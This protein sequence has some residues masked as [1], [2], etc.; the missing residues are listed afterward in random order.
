MMRFLA[1]ILSLLILCSAT[2]S[3]PV[4]IE[5]IKASMQ[6]L[7]ES[8]EKAQET[9]SEIDAR[10]QIA[11]A[12]ETNAA[13]ALD[14]G[15]ADLSELSAQYKSLYDEAVEIVRQRGLINLYVQELTSAKELIVRT[16][17]IINPYSQ[18][19]CQQSEEISKER[20]ELKAGKIIDAIYKIEQEAARQAQKSPDLV[21]KA[22]K[23]YQKLIGLRDKMLAFANKLDALGEILDKLAAI[24]AEVKNNIEKAS[25]ELDKALPRAKYLELSADKNQKSIAEM[26]KQLD[27][28]SMTSTQTLQMRRQLD[29]LKDTLEKSVK[30]SQE[31]IDKLKQSLTSLDER[32]NRFELNLTQMNDRYN[33]LATPYLKQTLNLAV[34]SSLSAKDILN[35]V[36]SA[37]DSILQDISA[38]TECKEQSLISFRRLVQLNLP[39]LTGKTVEEAVTIVKG[40]GLNVNILQT[41]QASSRALSRHVKSQNPSPG[42]KLK[43]GGK[44]DL[45]VYEEYAPIVIPDVRGLPVR[46]AESTLTRLELN[47]QSMP[48]IPAPAKNK[49]FTVFSQEPQAGARGNPG[50]TVTLNFYT[51]YE[52]QYQV[53]D[54]S[55]LTRDEAIA[56]LKSYLLKGDVH[57]GERAPSKSLEGKVY[58]QHPD[59]GVKI[60]VSVPV[61]FLIYG[62]FQPMVPKILDMNIEQGGQALINAG[63]I[64]VPIEGEA[65]PR[66]DLQ[67]II[68][69]Q[70]PREGTRLD[71]EGNVKITY[72][73]KKASSEEA[74]NPYFVACR[75]FIPIV[76]QD[77]K[78]T[79]KRISADDVRFVYSDKPV[80]LAIE[81]SGLTFY[82]RDFF[83][84]NKQL[85]TALV[86]LG[87]DLRTGETHQFDG[88]LLLEVSN[89]YTS[90]EQLVKAYPGAT[91]ISDKEL[92]GLIR[93]NRNDGRFGNIVIRDS[94]QLSWSGG[95]LMEGWSAKAKEAN[96]N[97]FKDVLTP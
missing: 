68:Y 6:R 61:V 56:R 5:G 14:K 23:A 20:D 50:D 35:S 59:A 11:D 79:G 38:I 81:D 16:S 69:L 70:V 58:A 4:N 77:S 85:S 33:L 49:S 93:F 78:V 9:A 30:N 46:S 73:T 1:A 18:E 94:I 62:T 47:I 22:Q 2:I 32:E 45:I 42:T 96:L 63:L 10:F 34:E 24:P 12:A 80:F 76:D 31:R 41:V 28:L 25:K 43:L 55:G 29:G 65:A 51:E 39:D 52:D 17:S 82:P 75:N 53:P 64:P 44:V 7:N 88:A 71:P 57:A 13:D 26:E 40:M 66:E 72:Y 15:L 8:L 60:P 89:I 90:R 21:A 27:A 84:T 67:G 83:K 87:K 95:P 36:T 37:R 92:L 48:D 19:I 97:L 74:E 3:P 54:L 86:I 91:N